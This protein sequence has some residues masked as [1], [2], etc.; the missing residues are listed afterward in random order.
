MEAHP[1]ELKA[2][3]RGDVR[4]TVPLF[5]R[6]YVWSVA[7]QWLPLWQD[8][9]TTE[10]RF[11]RGDYS[12]HFLGAV[13]L[14]HKPGGLGSLEVRE[15]IDGQQRLTTLQLFV[16]AVRDVAASSGNDP[17]LT[18]RLSKLVENDPDLVRDEDEQFRLWPTNRDRD[19]YAAALR[20]EHKETAYS[21]SLPRTVQA[22]AWFREHVYAWSTSEP[23]HVDAALARLADVITD[24]LQVVVIDLT[25]T[26]DAQVIFETLNARGTPLLAAD[27]IKNLLFRTLEAGQRPVE[28]LYQKLWSPLEDR[29]WEGELRQ[30]RLVRPQLDVFM[31]YFLITFLQQ[32]VLSHDLFSSVRKDVRA[33][34][35]RAEQM[36]ESINRYSEVYL[37][38]EACT[39]GTAHEQTALRRLRIADSQTVTPLLLWLFE[40]VTGREREQAIAALESFVVRR[41]ICGWST[42]N[43]NRIFLEILRR[44][45]AG[46]GPVDEV[47]R[48]HLAGLTSGSGL[49]PTDKNVVD[50]LA[51]RQVYLRLRRDQLRL[52][53]EAIESHVSSTRTEPM[54]VRKLSIEHLMPQAWEK[55]WELPEGLSE[56]DAQRLMEERDRLLHTLG[57]LTLVT[58]V[59][60]STMSNAEWSSKR[61]HLLEFSAL[62]MNRRLPLR[63]DIDE[64]VERTT[65][66]A[67]L[68]CDIWPRT[69]RLDSTDDIQVAVERATADELSV[70]GISAERRDDRTSSRGDIAAHIE[71]VFGDVTPGTFLT[72]SEISKIS[73]PA[74]PVKSPS[75]G[76]LSARLFPQGRET[77]VAGVRPDMQRGVRGATK[78]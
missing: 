59:L 56:D 55:H 44:L 71:F 75:P 52:L 60:N 22:Y 29:H 1:R 7:D 47:V 78:L 10:R 66:Y 37:E 6:S 49:W 54:A 26:D 41:A 43:Y 23:G 34:A 65:T 9:Q 73:T 20:G 18:R 27:L 14:Q 67:L 57:N 39:A 40:N 72:I 33:D 58:G 64:I 76:A 53:L 5:Q 36:L 15:I 2:V 51:G 74:Y 25:S 16:A 48:Q 69:D 12:P 35:E 31:N 8:V 45:G 21:A 28:S 30:G 68:V 19:S 24:G 3:F 62:T 4:L 13:V 42:A 70:A 63:W 46:E 17:R 77:T 50:E 61:E 11:A 32:E 38:V